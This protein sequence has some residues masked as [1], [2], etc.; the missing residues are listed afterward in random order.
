MIGSW[1]RIAATALTL[2]AP[3]LAADE[4]DWSVP[5]APFKI[6]GNAYYVGTQGIAAVLVT[7]PTGHLLI[8]GATPE[9]AQQIAANIR[10]LGFK[11]EDVKLIANS[12]IHFDHAGGIAELQR[13]SGATVK[14]SPASAPWL[15][16]GKVD[17]DDPQA[18]TLPAMEPTAKVTTIR[19]GEILK[20]G[21]TAV[22]AVFTPGH[23]SGGT[24]WT[25]KA[26]EGA[27]CLN[28]VY[29]DSITTAAS[30]GY[31][32]TEHPEVMAAFI[33]SF[34]VVDALP[35]DILV[36]VHPGF[37]DLWTRLAKREA[38][39]A[40]GLLDTGACHRYVAIMRA[41]MDKTIAGEKAK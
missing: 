8:D 33:K 39:N 27:R 22:R 28:I 32:F 14:A 4:N 6:F 19:D 35:C 25:W 11:V 17:A 40:D 18:A 26:C 30:G 38:G 7:S 10:T 34:A 13:L 2:V 23:T 16:S 20:I 29:A 41:W 5:H 3:A 21:T 31:R 15:S 37:S 12:H 36:S 1:L 24:T 9:A